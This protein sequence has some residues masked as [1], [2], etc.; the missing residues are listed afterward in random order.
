M[1]FI[2]SI[3]GVDFL[4]KWSTKNILTT[5]VTKTYESVK[6]LK[7]VGILNFEPDT[8]YKYYFG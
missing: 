4:T 1:R 3:L 6:G 7:H 5:E 2:I 8:G